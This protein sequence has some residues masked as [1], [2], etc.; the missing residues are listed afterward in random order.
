MDK[1]HTPLEIQCE[2][3]ADNIF[4]RFEQDEKKEKKREAKKR[5][6]IKLP[7]RMIVIPNSD[8]KFHEKWVPGRNI[9]DF[10]HPFRM[11]LAAKP[12]SGKTLAMHNVILRTAIGKHPFE[13]IVVVHCDPEGTNE[14]DKLDCTVLH[15]IPAPEDFDPSIKTL[16]IL[17][18]LNY[19]SMGK[20]QEGNLNRLYGY[21]S[22]HKNISCMLT[23]QNVFRVNPTVRRCTNIFVLW[24]SPDMDMIK[25]LARKIAVRPEE[26]CH[27]L[28]KHCTNYHDS[29]WLDFTAETPYPFRKNGFEVI[30][31]DDL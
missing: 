16:V 4:R 9:L 6:Q 17:E 20:I 18:D 3:I 26:L 7:N 14:Y 12:N 15:Q 29:L 31:R 1:S 10:P 23:A 2:L 13:S 27:A 5:K 22:T 21:V 25:A 11:V 8:K 30:S 24:S 28:E 19:T